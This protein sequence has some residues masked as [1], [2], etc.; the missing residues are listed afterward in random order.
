VI[1][2][3]VLQTMLILLIAAA[4]VFAFYAWHRAVTEKRK[5]EMNGKNPN[6]SAEASYRFC[7]RLLEMLGIRQKG[8]SHEAFAIAAEADCRLLESGRLSETIHM[9]QTVAFSREGIAQEE[10]AQIADTAFT[11]AD[12]IYRNANPF[13]R[14]WMKWFLHIV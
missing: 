8:M 7:I 1:M 5:R 10:A 2:K 11:L 9:M 3:Q 4:I 13:K 14:F 6:R 12:H